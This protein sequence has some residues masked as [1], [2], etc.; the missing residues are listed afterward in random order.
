MPLRMF[1]AFQQI[2]TPNTRPANVPKVPMA[3]PVK[4][5][6]RKME[7][8]VAPIVRRI[9]MLELLSFTNIYRPEMML[10]AATITTRDKTIDDIALH[11]QRIEKGHVAGLPGLH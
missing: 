10:R 6:T 1:S 4:K 8:L 7:P 2:N 11:R 5:N 3:A 9:A